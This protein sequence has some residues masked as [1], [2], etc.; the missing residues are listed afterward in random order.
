MAV[1]MYDAAYVYFIRPVGMRGPVKIGCSTL[2]E[3][4]LKDLMIWSPF[5]LEV[6]ARLAGNIRVEQQFHAKFQH[7]HTHGEWFRPDQELCET[8]RVIR[9]GAFDLSSLPKAKRLYAAKWSDEQRK[10]ASLS[11]R[12]RH[13][14]K[15]G[16]VT[17]SD[18][19]RALTYWWR[20]SPEEQ[21]EVFVRAEAHLAANDKREAA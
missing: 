13:L 3:R 6:A 21:L 8:I 17:P 14:E 16:I 20:K 11:H 12:I 2:P 1:G 4:R 18:L 9:A 19:S 5:E 10:H 15:R 7:L